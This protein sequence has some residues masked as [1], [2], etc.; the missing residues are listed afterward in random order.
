[1]TEPREY[2]DADLVRMMAEIAPEFNKFS[3]IVSL[4]FAEINQGIISL[5]R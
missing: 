1:M 5:G 2:Q 3:S 4:I